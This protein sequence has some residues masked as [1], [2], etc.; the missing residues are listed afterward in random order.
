MYLADKKIYVLRMG[1]IVEKKFDLKMNISLIT[2][3]P[4]TIYGCFS[5]S[6]V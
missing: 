5:G 6:E 2:N 1:K 4:L 3:S